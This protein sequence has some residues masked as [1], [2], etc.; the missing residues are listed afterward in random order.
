[1]MQYKLDDV[2]ASKSKIK[3]KNKNK[4][5]YH[6]HPDQVVHIEERGTM[7]QTRAWYKDRIKAKANSLGL[8]NSDSLE[9]DIS[10]PG[11]AQLPVGDADTQPE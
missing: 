8:G 1:M 5:I 7:N 11:E 3:I 9:K 6:L 2:Q 10:T 4:S